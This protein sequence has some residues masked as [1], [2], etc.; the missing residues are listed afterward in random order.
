MLPGEH[1]QVL[2]N[3]QS[4]FDD[5][6]E[7]SQESKIF[8]SSDT[9]QLEREVNV[10]KQYY[11]ELLKSAERGKT[12]LRTVERCSYERLWFLRKLLSLNTSSGEFPF[13][14]HIDI[15]SAPVLLNSHHFNKVHDYIVQKFLIFL[16]SYI[17]SYVKMLICYLTYRALQKISHARVY[18]VHSSS[19]FSHAFLVFEC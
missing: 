2:S 7:D 5:F 4:R 6:V 9:A 15:V 14:Y 12:F 13:F 16:T 17:L 18:S 1:Q 11:Q 10:C 3:L 8:T 19:L